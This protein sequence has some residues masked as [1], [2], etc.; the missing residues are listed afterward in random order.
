MLTAQVWISLIFVWIQ[1]HCVAL[2]LFILRRG[3]HHFNVSTHWKIT[4]RKG[5]CVTRQQFNAMNWV[6][7]LFGVVF[8][9]PFNNKGMTT[10][11][12]AAAAV[13]AA[14]IRQ[15]TNEN[16]FSVCAGLGT[17]YYLTLAQNSIIVVENVTM[18]VS[19]LISLSFYSV[20]VCVY[21]FLIDN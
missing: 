4:K 7:I 2:F 10:T 5:R 15:P 19:D 9:G 1:I 3:F 14:A 11:T 18:L 6:C 8:I 12:S 16:W 20:C 17:S 13:A 21:M